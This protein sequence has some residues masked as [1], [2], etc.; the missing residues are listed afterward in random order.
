MTKRE[1]VRKLAA[2]LLG[3]I[4]V[5]EPVFSYGIPFQGPNSYSLGSM[6]FEDRFQTNALPD[7][8]VA[9]HTRIL[10]RVP[11]LSRLIPQTLPAGTKNPTRNSREMNMKTFIASV[12]SGV[13]VIILSYKFLPLWVPALLGIL[14]ALAFPHFSPTQVQRVRRAAKLSLGTFPQVLIPLVRRLGAQPFEEIIQ[15]SDEDVTEEILNGIALIVDLIRTPEDLNSYWPVLVEIRR[16]GERNAGH[17]FLSG[18]LGVKSLIHNPNDLLRFGLALVDIGK[19][20]RRGIS[21]YQI[22]AIKK[23]ILVFGIEPFIQIV[24]ATGDSESL[25]ALI[26]EGPKGFRTVYLIKRYGIEIFVEIAQYGGK[27]AIDA[28]KKL[29]LFEEAIHNADDVKSF[30][31]GLADFSRT[32]GGEIWYYQGFYEV[33]DLVGIF[34]VE[35]FVELARVSGTHT[36]EVFSRGIPHFRNRFGEIFTNKEGLIADLRI[37]LSQL[38]E[39][40]GYVEYMDPVNAGTVHDVDPDYKGALSE[41]IAA[42]VK[43]DFSKIVPRPSALLGGA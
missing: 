21:Q 20:S 5:L 8:I 42:L 30:G 35:P 43:A 12:A 3:L 24:Q 36:N 19:A 25:T 16:A 2:A 17:H 38:R 28:F 31:K 6:L 39:P 32:V 15:S 34:G 10:R 27:Y 11:F 4:F 29:S 33:R 40:Y 18:F 37:L 13:V 7:P 1:I 14:G 26:S 41:G 22:G 9:V 23:L